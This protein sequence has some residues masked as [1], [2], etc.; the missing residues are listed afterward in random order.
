V[1]PQCAHARRTRRRAHRAQTGRPAAAP[2]QGRTHPQTVQAATGGRQQL[3]QVSGPSGPARLE[4][5]RTRPHRPHNLAAPAF[6]GPF[7]AR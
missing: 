7:P 1:R 3:R 4:I 2:K 5:G 6:T